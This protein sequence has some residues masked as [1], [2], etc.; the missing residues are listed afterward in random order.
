MSVYCFIAE[1]MI[2]TFQQ[3][4]AKVTGNVFPY[5]NPCSIQWKRLFSN[6]DNYLLS[7]YSYNTIRKKH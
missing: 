3:S 6:V 7:A 5:K 2:S 4:D 1:I